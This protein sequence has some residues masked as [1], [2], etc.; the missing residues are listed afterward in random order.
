MATADERP[1]LTAD[2]HTPGRDLVPDERIVYSSV[3][4]QDGRP[5]TVSLT[6]VEIHADGEGTRLVLTEQGAFLDDLEQPDWRE[7]DTDDWLDALGAE[8]RTD[9]KTGADLR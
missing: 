6:T 5:A 4:S 8:L 9:T 3:L 2:T 7:Q 1:I